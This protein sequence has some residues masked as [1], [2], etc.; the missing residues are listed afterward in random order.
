MF[1]FTFADV[2]VF[3]KRSRSGLFITVRMCGKNEDCSR[4]GASSGIGREFVLALDRAGG[5][6]EIWAVARRKERLEALAGECSTPVR[7]VP[8]DLAAN[9]AAEDLAGR[10]GAEKADV[11]MLVNGA[12]FGLF[13]EFAS[14]PLKEQSDMIELNARSLTEI[15][16]AVLPHIPEG[17]RIVNIASNSSWQPVPYM[18]VYAASK[19]Y[20]MSFSR[21]LGMELRE[22]GIGVTAVAPGWIRTEFFDRAVRDDTIKYYD[23]FYTPRQVAN[24][25]MKDIR[26]G[27]EVSIL[28]FPVRMQVRL[29][30]LLPVKMVMNTWCR[31]QGKSAKK[32]GDR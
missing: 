31:Q 2:L 23:R 32:K 15:T 30:K 12:G 6:D 10:I 28:G 8:M 5:F 17:G 27:K 14:L 1:R 11:M 22:I 25:A 4:H 9:G 18:A 7:P 21:A 29:V 13:G 20:V 19:A 16:Y 24:R 3:C 26:K